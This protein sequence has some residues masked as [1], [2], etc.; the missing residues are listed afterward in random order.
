MIEIALRKIGSKEIAAGVIALLLVVLGLGGCGPDEEATWV[1]MEKRVEISYGKSEHAITYAYL[2]QYAHRVSYQRHRLL[3][4]YLR[5]KTGLPVRQI[6]PNTFDEHVKM[7]GQGQIDISFSNPFIYV[8]LARQF[9]AQAIARSVEKN[10]QKDFRGR[11]ICRA[12][13]RHIRSIEDCRGKRWIAVD[14]SSAGGY[15][16][17]LGFFV[18]HGLGPNDFAEIAFAPGSAGKQEK[19]VLAVFF[20]RYDIGSIREGTLDVVADKIDRRLIRV[21]ADTP[22]YPGWVYAV[23]RGLPPKTVARI[24]QA[25]ID[26]DPDRP[27]DRRILE[28]A[29]FQRIIPSDDSEFDAVRRLATRLKMDLNH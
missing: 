26:L 23:R 24:R 28:A 12:D 19:V 18:D 27:E 9:G 4:E 7:V 13:N 3:V 6:F 11:I 2:P 21:L 8:K 16:Y 5:K 15:L 20:G 17:P 22:W 1:D 25:L 10:G 29:N 14:P